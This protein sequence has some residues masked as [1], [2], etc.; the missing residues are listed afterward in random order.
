MKGK[1]KI[2]MVYSKWK[3]LLQINWFADDAVRR[4]ISREYNKEMGEFVQ[5][6]RRIQSVFAVDHLN[7]LLKELPNSYHGTSYTFKRAFSENTMYGY[8]GQILKYAGIRQN[9]ML[10][11]PLLEHGILYADEFDAVRYNLRHSYIFQGRYLEDK[12][13]RIKNHRKAYYIGPYIH[14]AD[15]IYSDTQ[16]AEIKKKLGRTILLFLPHS[17]EY[18]NINIDIE[19]QIDGYIRKQKENF[20][21]VL[22]C[23]FWKD[24]ND[25]FLKAID[26]KQ[27]KICSAGFKLDPL[28]VRRLKSII[29]LADEVL[30][31]SFLSSIGYAYDLNKKVV[32]DVRED[33]LKGDKRF[34]AFNAEFMKYFSVE[35]DCDDKERYEYIDRY[36]GL[37]EKKSP[38]EIRDIYLDNKKLL[39]QRLGF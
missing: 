11:F 31:T 14:Y 37:S 25:E 33:I 26:R 32:A 1:F 19:N 27:F 20:D 30:F 2:V 39:I 9:Q 24:I 16:I 13:N 18:R 8:A 17:T 35:S 10:Y 6:L 36:W 7:E 12:W 3:S 34:A 15:S 29:L 5:K 38:E 23:V 4:F 22:L 21:T 28:F